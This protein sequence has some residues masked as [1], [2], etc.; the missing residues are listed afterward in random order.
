MLAGT[1]IVPLVTEVGRLGICFG[2][3]HKL[4]DGFLDTGSKK[5]GEIKEDAEVFV[6]NGSS[7]Y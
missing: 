6:L 4:A 5:G 1:R 3:S 7:N 2:G